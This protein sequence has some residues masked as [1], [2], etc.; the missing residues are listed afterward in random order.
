[1]NN[2]NL[3]QQNKKQ[4]NKKQKMIMGKP[5]Q[6][7]DADLKTAQALLICAYVSPEKIKN[8]PIKTLGNIKRC[9]QDIQILDQ[10][11]NELIQTISQV[12]LK[13]NNIRQRMQGMADV[14]I[15]LI[16]KDK[17]EELAAEAEVLGA[18]DMKKAEE[19]YMK[20]FENNKKLNPIESKSKQS[21][22]K[23]VEDS[24]LSKSPES[25]EENKNVV[26]DNFGNPKQENPDAK[27][28]KGD[29]AGA[30]GKKAIADVV[31][32]VEDKNRSES[33][34]DNIDSN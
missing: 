8:V 10:K 21:E 29:I 26:E 11:R 20:S 34:P 27:Q 16:D 17:F 32:K 15:D 25:T 28:V 4:Q 3:K 7:S 5:V 31:K 1:M 2:Q 23:K 24:D 12:D 6:L 9:S 22:R 30:A 33:I 14:A 13:L 19:N 18:E